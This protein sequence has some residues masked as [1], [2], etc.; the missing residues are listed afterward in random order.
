MWAT[1]TRLTVNRNLLIAKRM[2]SEKILPCCLGAVL[3]VSLVPVLQADALELKN[4]AGL[5]G[6]YF[7]KMAKVMPAKKV[8][9]FFRLDN[10]LNMAAD[11]QIEAAPLLIK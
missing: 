7:E 2:N 4:G 5:N 10:Q 11:L 6:K 8:A 3:C 1:S 9:R